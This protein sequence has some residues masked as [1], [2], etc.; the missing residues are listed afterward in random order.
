MIALAAGARVAA[1]AGLLA[2]AARRG[3]DRG[4]DTACLRVFLRCLRWGVATGAATGAGIG[5]LVVAVSGL[6]NGPSLLGLIP[7]GVLYGTVIGAL[8]SV[9]PSVLGGLVVTGLIWW[10]HPHPSSAEALYGDLGRILCAVVVLLDAALLMAFIAGGAGLSSTAI[11]LPFVVAG[12][13][14]VVMMLCRARESIGRS[15]SEAAR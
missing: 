12:N 15:W 11:S 6:G 1:S 14:C 7:I 13:A 3:P 2:V 8:V 5:G 10:R 4:P 9:I